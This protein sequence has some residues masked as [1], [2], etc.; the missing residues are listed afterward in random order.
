M[1]QVDS[2]FTV[3]TTD[4]VLVITDD[5]SLLVGGVSLISIMWLLLSLTSTDTMALHES[6][7]EQRQDEISHFRLSNSSPFLPRI[8]VVVMATPN[9]ASVV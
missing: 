1:I 4:L 3:S 5:P 8:V 7:V 6:P 9:E 2:L